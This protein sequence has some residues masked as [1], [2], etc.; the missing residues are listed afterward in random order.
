[1]NWRYYWAVRDDG[2]YIWENNVKIAVIEPD[3]FVHI[4]HDMAQHLKWQEKKNGTTDGDVRP[5]E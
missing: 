1:M 2:L 4:I 3:Q 5:E